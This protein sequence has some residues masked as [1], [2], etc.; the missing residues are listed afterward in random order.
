MDPQFLKLL[1]LLEDPDADNKER[2]KKKICQDYSVCMRK[3]INYD[4]EVSL[5]WLAYLTN[6]KVTNKA[7]EIKKNDSSFERH[8]QFLAEVQT[9]YLVNMF[10]NY[11]EDNKELLDAVEDTKT[12]LFRAWHAGCLQ[13]SPIL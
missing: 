9:S 10:D 13:H 8:D 11:L 5:L 1:E 3:E 7:K 4:D 6:M 12:A 2:E